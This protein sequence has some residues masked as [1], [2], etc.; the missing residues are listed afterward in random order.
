M[1]HLLSREKW[2]RGG[3]SQAVTMGASRAAAAAGQRHPQKKNKRKQKP[4]LRCRHCR[5]RIAREHPAAVEPQTHDTM[6]APHGGQSAGDGGKTRR[7]GEPQR[8][9]RLPLPVIPPTADTDGHAGTPPGVGTPPQPRRRRRRRAGV[10][11]AS[12]E[13]KNL[14]QTPTQAHLDRSYTRKEAPVDPPLPAKEARCRRGVEP[15]RPPVA[16]TRPPHVAVATAGRGGPPPPLPLSTRR[17]PVGRRAD[18]PP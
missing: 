16:A 11:H 12:A 4:R 10:H 2:T 5:D 7:G 18:H 13:T 15:R 1:A 14:V 8:L 9:G 6:C 17:R 3:G